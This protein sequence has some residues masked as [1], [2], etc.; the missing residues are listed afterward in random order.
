MKRAKDL[1]P[2]SP[3]ITRN[4]G[5]PL[6]YEHR[7]DEYIEFARQ[8]LAVDPDF[9]GNHFMLGWAYQ[10]KGDIPQSLAAYEKANQMHEC[11]LTL[12]HLAHA[13]A[14]AGKKSEARK[15]LAALQA[16]ATREYVPP[17]LIAFV[18][19]G[20]GDKTQAL[21]WLEKAYEERYWLMIS[22][23]TDPRWDSLRSE[24]RFQDL[25]RRVGLT[26]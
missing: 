20:L 14:L 1:D 10:M 22:L 23:K 21:V 17:F 12:S 15:L 2:L 9:W 25:E 11:P 6:F 16:R 18:Y 8:V 5:L 3:I 4:V 24:A 19:A 26:P 7:Y 13:Y